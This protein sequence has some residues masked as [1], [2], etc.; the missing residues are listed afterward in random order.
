M[1]DSKKL[2]FGGTLSV[3]ALPQVSDDALGVFHEENMN[4]QPDLAENDQQNFQALVQDVAFRMYVKQHGLPTELATGFPLVDEHF[5]IL[6]PGLT[7]IDGVT[8]VGKTAFALQIVAQSLK[9]N[10]RP[11][12]YIT[13]ESKKDVAKRLLCHMAGITSAQYRKAEFNQAEIK[14]AMKEYAA[15]GKNL[16]IIQGNKS[17]Y[18]ST[19]FQKVHTILHGYYGGKIP[20]ENSGIVIVDTLEDVQ[21]PKGI[22]STK[23]LVTETVVQELKEIVRTFRN[24][25]VVLSTTKHADTTVTETSDLRVVVEHKLDTVK[26]NLDSA[27]DVYCSLITLEQD[28]DK[29]GVKTHDN[30]KVRL[31]VSKNKHASEGVVDFAYDSLHDKFAEAPK[32][33]QTDQ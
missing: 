9:S 30:R 4:L 24:P 8:K 5:A 11:V 14:S 19:I 20:L 28:N 2:D 13:W 33:L 21:Y 16:Y 27:A 29:G 12:I 31:L 22:G 6:S 1:A 10:P 7:V 3:D 26:A 25:L 17:M 23:D 32:S 18:P 15:L